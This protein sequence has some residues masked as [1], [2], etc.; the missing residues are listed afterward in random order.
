MDI[1]N[2]TY[3]LSNELQYFA[4]FTMLL[5]LPKMLLRFQIPSAL[6]ALAL[7]F[8][9]NAT[10]GWFQND[11]L[12]LM[13]SRLGITSLFL[14]AGMEVD[15]DDLK[16]DSTVLTKHLVKIVALTF[17]SGFLLHY[18][19]K[20]DFRIGLVLALGLMTPSTGFILNSLKGFH[21]TPHQERWVRSKAISKELV[22]IFLLFFTLQTESV[23]NF[24]VSSGSLIL[25]IIVLPVLFKFFLKA[26]APFA[27]D[28]EVT[29][30]ILIALLCGVITAKLGTYYLVGAFI[31]GMTAGRFRHFIEHSKSQNMLYS[32]SLFFTFFVPF[33]F[34]RAGLTFSVQSFSMEGLT[35]GLI[36]L[37]VF[38]PLRFLSVLSSIWFFMKDSW[39]DRKWISIPLLP[40]LIFGLVIAS[41]LRER[42]NAPDYIVTGLMIYTLIASILPWFFLEKSRP[43]F[44]DS[45]MVRWREKKNGETS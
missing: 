6:T 12:L 13:L 39:K 38:L 35:L 40:T 7:G 15:I 9:T 10:L 17:L 11:E 24:L 25:M 16:E 26:V 43:E 14:F 45:S 28:S 8:L 1:E 41:I 3:A 36:F 18:F 22:A 27:P 21:L 23:E 32:V 34:Y 19:L 33:Y 31:V 2:P 29:F 42:L 20:V 4:L 44:Y 5:I 30:L 37:G